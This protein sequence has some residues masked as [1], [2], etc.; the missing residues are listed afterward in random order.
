MLSW[1]RKISSLSLFAFVIKSFTLS[2][3]FQHTEFTHV[4]FLF[5]SFSRATLSRRRAK[6][7]KMIS[8]L[9][10]LFLLAAPLCLHAHHS[11]GSWTP[12]CPSLACG[13]T[14]SLAQSM[15][16]NDDDDF[17]WIPSKRTMTISQNV[18]CSGGSFA[19]VISRYE[20]NGIY[21]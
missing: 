4:T 6:Q 16:C 9:A 18:V 15:T 7:G 14:M 12:S 10:L 19:L 5:E 17:L 13:V 8:R 21:L 20:S 3:E 1:L 2:L 11:C